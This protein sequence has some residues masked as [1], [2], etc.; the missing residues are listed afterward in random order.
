M[1]Y[2]AILRDSVREAIDAKILYVMLALSAVLILLCLSISFKP[3][4]AHDLLDSLGLLLN[5]PLDDQLK[6]IKTTVQ[7]GQGA[8]P[9][10]QPGFNLFK[11]LFKNTHS[12]SY[13]VK[14]AEPLPG[15]SDRPGS[16]FVFTVLARYTR[17]ADADKVRQD[18]APE[19]D[20]IRERFASLGG[21]RRFLDVT[22]VRP[23]GPDNPVVRDA[24]ENASDRDVYFEVQTRPNRYTLAVW[25]S[26]PY[27]LTWQ[28]TF[29][30]TPQGEG[31]PLGMQL[32]VIVE[33]LANS[34]GTTV[35]LLVSIVLTSLFIPNM[36]RKGTIDL[37]LVKPIRRWALLVYK[38]L[39]GLTFILLNTTVLIGGV[40]LA[41]GLRS[42]L[43]VNSLLL[44]IPVLVMVFAFL[45]AVS[46]LCAVATRSAIVAILLSCLVWGALFGVNVTYRVIQEQHKEEVFK[47]V[48][49]ERRFWE[50]TWVDVVSGVHHAL[51]RYRDLVM[52][53]SQQIQDELFPQQEV[54]K[55]DLGEDPV[56]W[57][58]SLGVTGAYL[59]GLLGLSCAI[60]SRKDY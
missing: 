41:L 33:L 19:A 8:E 18:P 25:P 50:G 35:I 43:W 44:V 24:G 48:P 52:F 10:P 40:W 32:L 54:L 5:V 27:F 53:A 21:G 45:Y 6:E 29:A 55:K 56:D 4:P 17:S 30:Q 58:Q 59:V 22:E 3:R 36:L 37:L 60:F 46:T 31:F 15:E 57:R 47:N 49:P 14:G 13:Q 9:R 28:L 12:V 16:R 38:Y 7:Q 1:K 42:G 23:A 20:V 51:P 34:V 11:G 2:L 39:G 26:D